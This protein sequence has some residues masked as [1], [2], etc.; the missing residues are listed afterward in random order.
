MYYN[1]YDRFRSFSFQKFVYRRQ[2][3]MKKLIAVVLIVFSQF[4]SEDAF[5]I[6][7]RIMNGRTATERQF[8]F[9]VYLEIETIDDKFACGGTLLNE[10]FILTAAHCFNDAI[11]IEVHLGAADI[12]SP[13]H[14]IRVEEHSFFKYPDYNLSSVDRLHD[15]GARF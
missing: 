12:T 8:P 3:K 6:K 1:I 2:V 14:V 7:P 10:K 15:I 4:Q 5:K 13:K 11:A 9:Y